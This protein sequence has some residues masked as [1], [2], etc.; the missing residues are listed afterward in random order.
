MRDAVPQILTSFTLAASL[1]YAFPAAPPPH[2]SPT[3]ATVRPQP[4]PRREAAAL[5]T[6]A[7]TPAP[8]ESDKNGGVGPGGRAVGG[9]QIIRPRLPVPRIKSQSETKILSD[10]GPLLP[11]SF[12]TSNLTLK[13]F[14]NGDWPLFIAY[15][16]EEPGVVTLTVEAKDHPPFVRQFGG[17]Q[18]GRHEEMLRLPAA[19]GRKPLAGVYALRAASDSSPAARPVP[20]HL[21]ALGAGPKAV[22]SSGFDRVNFQPGTVVSHQQERA[23]YSFHA[24]R[25][26]NWATA[27]FMRLGRNA[28]REIVLQRVDR[29]N[30]KKGIRKGQTL[31]GE[32]NCKLLGGQASVG[33]HELYVRGWR[34]LGKGAD[35]MITSSVPQRVL[36]R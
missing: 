26:F 14:V 21:Q 36:V 8:A 32:W 17:T 27:D 10:E 3:V 25:D 16:L 29:R 20:L 11:V 6:P 1:V 5:S 2:A 12:S 18:P 34:G 9:G 4:A 33:L 13:A 31:S 24:I 23:S 22:G 15:E 7:L 28:A 19:F 30:F 35:W